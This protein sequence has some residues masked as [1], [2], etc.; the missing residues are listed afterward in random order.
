MMAV[1][2]LI[3]TSGHLNPVTVV[4]ATPL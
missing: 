4:C 3:L 1:L 2:M